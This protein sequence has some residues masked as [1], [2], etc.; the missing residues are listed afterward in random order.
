VGFNRGFQMSWVESKTKFTSRQDDI[1]TY[2][3]GKMNE[4]LSAL[5]DAVSSFIQKGGV[6]A[7]DENPDFNTINLISQTINTYKNQIVQLNKDVTNTIQTLQSNSDMDALLQKNGELQKQIDEAQ[8]NN[9][10][11]SVDAGSAL[12]RDQVL[13]AK[14]THINNGQVYLLGHPLRPASIPYLWGLS[15]LFIGIAVLLLYYYS[16]LQSIPTE[17]LIAMIYEQIYN[18]WMWA[19]LLGAAS[20]VILFLILGIMGLI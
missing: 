9:K 10:E 1:A 18:P 3:S 7:S 6:T 11:L 5:G 2:V 19:S 8:K 20:I 16:P 4:D 12:A 17:V 15:I 13:R 14:S